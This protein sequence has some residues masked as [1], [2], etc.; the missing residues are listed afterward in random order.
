MPKLNHLLYD[1]VYVV[2]MRR[3]GNEEGHTYVEGVYTTWE[4]AEKCMK[5]HQMWRDNKY[6]GEIKKF[7][8]NKPGREYEELLGG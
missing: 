7:V 8:L 6:E 1:H 4:A 3:F 2:I 5:L